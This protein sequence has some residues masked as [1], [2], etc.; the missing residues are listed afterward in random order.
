MF[1]LA[2]P[3]AG[4]F[5]PRAEPLHNIFRGVLAC[6]FT[7]GFVYALFVHRAVDSPARG[8]QGGPP[9]HLGSAIL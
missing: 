9:G 7:V 5:V 8:G 2:S 1:I 3:P 4:R 6:T